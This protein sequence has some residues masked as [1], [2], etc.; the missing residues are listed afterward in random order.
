MSF[1]A[2]TRR[3]HLRFCKIEGW[4]E[5]RSATG[6]PSRH[7]ATFELRI[8]SGD[9]LR[10]RIS[11]S[12]RRKT[13]GASLWAHILRDQLRVSEEEF[14]RCVRDGGQPDRGSDPVPPSA[15]PSDLVY[16]LRNEVGL[17]SGEIAVMSLQEAVERMQQH[18]MG[19]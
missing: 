10:T 17:S 15:L 19:G 7:H 11:R 3:D 18:W 4:E 12:S 1:P 14:W 16:Q 6:K 2:P 9:I 13:Y 8:P 5:V